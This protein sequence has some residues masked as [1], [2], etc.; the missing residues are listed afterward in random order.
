MEEIP[1][2]NTKLTIQTIPK[3]TLL[4]R[5][6]N[7]T[8]NDTRGV[9][10]DDGTR[11]I[12]PNFNVY[13]YPNPFVMKYAAGKFLGEKLKDRR[14]HVYILNN[15]VKVIKLL[16]PSKY[17]RQH[18]GTKRSFIKRCSNVPKGCMPGELGF[19][20]PCLSDTIVEKYPDIV[21]MTGVA[22]YDAYG[23]NKALNHKRTL[24]V[25]KYFK[26]AEDA[27]GTVGI[28][29]L[30]LHP[31]KKR[32]SEQVIVKPTDK[33]E[34]NYKLLKILSLNEKELI[35]FMDKHSVY[36]P[37]TFYYTYTV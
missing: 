12:I 7:N 37:E 18:K 4:F 25:R 34:T 33:L 36:N 11:C 27:A 19:R 5:M 15:D 30:V 6:T 13:F 22:V 10:L 17:T 28:P 29:E 21:G 24:K 8:L 1:Y 9:P 14:M 32:P 23:V 35:K 2:R 26:L 16:L 31:L 3:G 20:D